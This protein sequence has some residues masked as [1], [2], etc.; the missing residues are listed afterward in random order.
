MHGPWP[1][2]SGRPRQRN[3]S[4]GW[5]PEHGAFPTTGRRSGRDMATAA[6]AVQ[7]LT[8][9]RALATARAA[10][11]IRGAGAA[12]RPP[13]PFSAPP[14]P[15]SRHHRPAA[16]DARPAAARHLEIRGRGVHRRVRRTC[17][18]SRRGTGC[19]V[20]QVEARSAARESFGRAERVGCDT[21][22]RGGFAV[23]G[24]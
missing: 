8:R 7:A 13:F 10:G 16:P 21:R 19:P 12:P 14:A 1:G 20:E 18:G 22:A 15:Q 9:R 4:G 24:Q 23:T 6:V 2:G 5:A 17:P 3:P 11:L